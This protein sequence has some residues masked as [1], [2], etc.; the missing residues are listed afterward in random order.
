MQLIV[1]NP[2]QTVMDKLH[3]SGVADLIGLDNI[4]LT[5]ADAV[6]T[7]SPILEKA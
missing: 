3:S 2:G 4:F 7:H 6:L 5:V 1:T